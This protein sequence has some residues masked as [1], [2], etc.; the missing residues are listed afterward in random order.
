MDAK[1]WH[2]RWAQNEIAFHMNEANPLLVKYFG[3]L[4]LA[5]GARIFLPLCGKTLD[6]GW[7]L[8]NGF[9]VVGAELSKLAVEQLFDHLKITPQ[10]SDLGSGLVHYSG[11]N[12]DIF[13][14]DIFNLSKATLG[15]VDA[16]YDRAALVAL[17]EK[18]RELYA[19]HLMTITNAAP[20][21]LIAYEYDQRLVDGPPFSVSESEIRKLY[22]STYKLTQLTSLDVPGGLKK[23]FPATENVWRLV[24]N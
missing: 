3:T 7:L 22:Q 16:V 6:A 1:F 11:I 12:I 17:P 2:Q 15:T 21:L 14:G 8:A 10:T 4:S 13:V 19:A 24:A 9:C 5:K 20:Q 23:K 18:T